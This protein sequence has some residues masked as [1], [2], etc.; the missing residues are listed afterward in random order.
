MSAPGVVLTTEAVVFDFN[1]T[2]ADD[3]PILESIFT[4]LLA[5]HGVELTT[6]RYYRDLAGLSDPEIAAR[7]LA[8]RGGRADPAAV[9]ALVRDKGLL[10]RRRVA[11]RSPLR[12]GAAALVRALAARVPVG[13]VSGAPRADVE[14][15]LSAAGVL[16]LLTVVVCAEDVAAGKPDPEGYRRALAVLA[17]V[18]PGAVVAVEDSPAGLAAA[19]AAGMRCLAVRGTA[20]DDALAAEADGVLDDLDPTLAVALLDD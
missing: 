8:L 7:G 12:P 17:P 1:G 15:V 13:V 10:Y 11:R 3:E 20:D 4:Q 14:T 16:D 9:T 2:L 6:E 5:S 19:R 18:T